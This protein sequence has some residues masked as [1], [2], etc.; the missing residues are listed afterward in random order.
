VSGP[1]LVGGTAAEARNLISGNRGDGVVISNRRGTQVEG[2]YIGT[3]V[4]GTMAVANGG[5]GVLIAFAATDNMVGGTSAGAGNLI[6]GNQRNGISIG[7]PPG[8][9]SDVTGNLVQGNRIGTDVTGTNPLGN[10][11][12][13]VLVVS[14]RAHGN[15]VGGEAPGAGNTI[16]FNGG[17]GV[18]V[19]T[20]TGDAIL[21]NAIFTNGHLGI[22]LLH[23]A[24]HDQPA[25]VLTAATID[26]TSTTVTGTLTSTPNTTFT[27]EFFANHPGEASGLEG[28][29]FL[30]SVVVATDADGNAS[31]TATFGTAV[32]PDSFLTATAT[33]AAN[34]TSPF[35]AAVA[36]IG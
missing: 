24:N 1:N 11:L 15:I 21:G 8:S 17:D 6:S 29:V 30:G 4:T 16:A 5:N 14:A 7:Q 3:D 26:G 12:N 22:E 19:D 32:D 36:V 31:F 10:G 18:L 35:S 25:P 23:G 27:L 13:G 20:G 9:G 33:D 34:N 2:N 28:E